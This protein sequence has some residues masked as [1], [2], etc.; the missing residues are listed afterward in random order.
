MSEET[1]TLYRP[2][3]QQE[4]ELIRES[5]WAAFPPWLPFQPIFYPVTNEEYAVQIARRGNPGFGALDG[6]EPL[7]VDRQ[8]LPLLDCS[9]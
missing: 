4:L 2:V 3:G 7:I 9:Q 5:G 8:A 6:A 1:V